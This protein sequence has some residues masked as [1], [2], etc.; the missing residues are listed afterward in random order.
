MAFGN[1]LTYGTQLC[2]PNT[3]EKIDPQFRSCESFAFL[4]CRSIGNAHGRIGY[5][6]KDTAMKYTRRIG[7]LFT[8]LEFNDGRSA[9]DRREPKANQ[10]SNR[11]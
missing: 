8:G 4:K 11:W 10:L 7:M 2:L 1:N 3:L 9:S 6:T 5:V